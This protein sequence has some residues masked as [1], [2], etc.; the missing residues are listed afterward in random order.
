MATRTD[1]NN[2]PISFAVLSAVGEGAPS[3]E[4]KLRLITSYRKNG[5]AAAAALDEYFVDEVAAKTSGLNDA[6]ENIAQLS[7]VFK[8]LTEPALILARFLARHPDKRLAEVL[9]GNNRMIL[10]VAPEVDLNALS[11][12]DEVVLNQKMTTVLAASPFPPPMH[13]QTATFQRLLKDGR[14][15]VRSG[16]E[17]TIIGVAAIAGSVWRA[18]DI[19]RYDPAARLALENIPQDETGGEFRLEALPDIPLSKVGGQKENFRKLISAMTLAITAPQTA[20]RYGLNGMMRTIMLSGPPGTGKTHMVK[21]AGA[22]LQRI[23]GRHCF[24][25]VVKPGA[26]EDK[27]VGETQKRIRQTFQMMRRHEGIS[28]LFID[29]I[30]SIGRARGGLGNLL[31]DKFLGALLVELQGTESDT[32]TQLIVVAASNRPDMLDP[33]VMS[34]FELQL[35]VGRPDSRAAREIFEIHLPCDL[36]FHS[37]GHPGSVEREKMIDRA[38]SMFFAPNAIGPLAVIKFRDG[39]QR[40]IMPSDLISGRCIEQLCHAARQSAAFRE[41]DGGDPGVTQHDLEEAVIEAQTNLGSSLTRHNIHQYLND[42]RQDMEIVALEPVVRRVR[43]PYR[44]LNP[45]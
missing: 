17:E 21:V 6:K 26:W 40:N 15:I 14:M 9:V 22:H 12:G 11:A 2:A 16:D 3:K 20:T 35:P 24:L 8:A 43:K 39:T 33:A 28:L 37:N 1:R 38:V 41:V 27:Y 42:L 25:H 7:E 32:K 18:G 29:E 45:I 30:E 19:V 44:F 4:E 31:G 23:T 10:S 13:G 5:P 34:R 36:P